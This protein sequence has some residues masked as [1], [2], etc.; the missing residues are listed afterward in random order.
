MVNI[1]SDVLEII[2]GP[3]VR[4]YLTDFVSKMMEMCWEFIFYL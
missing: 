4:K 1:H 3:P 2:T